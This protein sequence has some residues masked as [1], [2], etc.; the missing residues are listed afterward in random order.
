[1]V[2]AKKYFETYASFL[3][4][5]LSSKPDDE[6]LRL[7]NQVRSILKIIQKDKGLAGALVDKKV[8]YKDREK[9]LSIVI[10]DILPKLSCVVL[11]LCNRKQIDLL[12]EIFD[13]LEQ[14][15]EDK[16]GISFVE[17]ISFVPLNYKLCK[18]IRSKC[19]KDLGRKVLL[20]EQVSKEILGGLVL[21]YKFKRLD[22]SLICRLESL[23]AK[24]VKSN[25]GGNN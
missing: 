2:K 5:D 20:L 1:M 4:E 22:A 18:K 13:C 8:L 12:P 14:L 7:L 6:L 25:D 16:L 15:I 11:E 9:L 24:L 10:P 23:K 19:E 17:V 3:F 21:N